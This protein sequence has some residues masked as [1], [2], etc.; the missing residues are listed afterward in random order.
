MAKRSLFVGMEVHKESIDVSLAE[1]G[2]ASRA[3]GEPSRSLWTS[4]PSTCPR[5]GR[6][7]SATN[8]GLGGTQP[9]DISSVNRR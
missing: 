6:V 4:A 9:A 5:L 7:S 1:E 2:R 3:G 8:H